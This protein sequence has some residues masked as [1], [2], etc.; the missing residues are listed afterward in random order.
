MG[1]GIPS[2][3]GAS[4]SSKLSPSFYVVHARSRMGFSALEWFVGRV[5][6]LGP[7]QFCRCAE[8]IVRK[9]CIAFSW[10]SDWYAPKVGRRFPNSSRWKRGWS[11]AWVCRLS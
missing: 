8:R 6:S 2:L 9:M 7:N 10:S 11:E 5:S 4:R 1:S 3:A